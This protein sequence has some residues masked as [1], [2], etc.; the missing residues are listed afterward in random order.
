MNVLLR[1]P[2]ED[3]AASV[4]GRKDDDAAAHRR[5]RSSNLAMG[6]CRSPEVPARGGKIA[7]TL[8]D[9]RPVNVGVH[10]QASF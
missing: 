3:E 5:I 2:G 10:G 9:I 4:R 7:M 6:R 1:R 8:V